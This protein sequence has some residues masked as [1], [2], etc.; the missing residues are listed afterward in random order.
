MSSVMSEDRVS[1]MGNFLLFVM[2]ME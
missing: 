1:S 2:N